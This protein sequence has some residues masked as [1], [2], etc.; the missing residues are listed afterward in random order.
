MKS[1]SKGHNFLSGFGNEKIIE[2]IYVGDLKKLRPGTIVSENEHRYKI[3]V[4]IPYMNSED[5]KVEIEN[6]KLIIDGLKRMRDTDEGKRRSYKGIF[7]IPVDVL[8]RDLDVRYQDG[9][10][11]VELPKKKIVQQFQSNHNG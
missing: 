6:D 11:K 10:L 7:Q 8:V 5:I 4:G 3:E 2:D 1:S 9:L